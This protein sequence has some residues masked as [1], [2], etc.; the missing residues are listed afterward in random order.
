[1]L[2]APRFDAPDELA[3]VGALVSVGKDVF[4]GIAEGLEVG[5]ACTGGGVT[6]AVEVGGAEVGA[7]TL[8]GSAWAVL[9]N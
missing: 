8:V 9:I 2:G 1:M 6:V 7:A 5:V 3:L 4:V